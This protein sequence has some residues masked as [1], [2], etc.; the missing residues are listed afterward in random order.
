MNLMIS[1]AVAVM[2]IVDLIGLHADATRPKVGRC[3]SA[4]ARYYSRSV[5]EKIAST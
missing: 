4:L 1:M 5:L 2:S 3:G